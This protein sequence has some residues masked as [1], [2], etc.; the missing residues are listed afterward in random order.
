MRLKLSASSPSS[1]RRRAGTRVAKSP[2]A[3]FG[4]AAVRAP[5]GR[6]TKRQT[7]SQAR[8]STAR[9]VPT[10]PKSSCRSEVRMLRSTLASESWTSSTP[11]IVCCALWA[12]QGPP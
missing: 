4:A 12:W 1:S 6:S 8:A 3:T 7:S 11:R 2:P 9:P 5:T 10:M